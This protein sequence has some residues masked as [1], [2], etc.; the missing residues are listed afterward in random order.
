MSDIK[1]KTS[2]DA[3]HQNDYLPSCLYKLAIGIAELH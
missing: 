1:K 3:I 2:T